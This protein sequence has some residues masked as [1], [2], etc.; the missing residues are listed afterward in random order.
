MGN[1]FPVLNFLKRRRDRK[2]EKKIM[3]SDGSLSLTLNFLKSPVSPE[4]V[5]TCFLKNQFSLDRTATASLRATPGS[6][7][8]NQDSTTVNS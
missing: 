3:E 7:A 8:K 1:I 5:A 4:V 2:P 6:S